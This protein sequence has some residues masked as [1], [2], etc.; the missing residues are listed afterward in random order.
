MCACGSRQGETASLEYAG[1][2]VLYNIGNEKSGIGKTYVVPV[3]IWLP[4]L[5]IADENRQTKLEG[6][7][8]HLRKLQQN[9]QTKKERKEEE[10]L[11]RHLKKFP[12]NFEFINQ[13]LAV[14]SRGQNSDQ[15][16]NEW[17]KMDAK[18]HYFFEVVMRAKKTETPLSSH[19]KHYY[20]FNFKNHSQRH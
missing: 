4:T 9:K 7:A 3:K 15:N 12:S 1:P 14:T 2:L 16:T 20:Y 6:D 17:L 18:Y 13:I 19:F 8:N 11:S 5:C 10:T